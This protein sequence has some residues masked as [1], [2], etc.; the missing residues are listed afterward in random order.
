MARPADAAWVLVVPV[1][2]GDIAKSRLTGVTAR[3]RT[4]LARAFP[5]DCTEAAL[6]CRRVD[7]AVVVTDDP[8]AADAVRA[9]G[10]DVIADEPDAG[11]NPALQHA[12]AHVQRRYGPRPVAVISGDLPALR[13]AELDTALAR[14]SGFARA[15]VHDHAGTGTTLLTAAPGVDLDP[16]FGHG[17]RQRHARSGAHELDPRGLD[18]LR[19]DVDTWADLVDACRLGV[20]RHTTAVMRRHRLAA[21]RQQARD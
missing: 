11:L 1:K 8:V 4:D 3:Q 5:A 16:R 10:A 19:R 21:V 9:L 17:S 18:G 12:H 6:A 7:A 15:F 14:A 13:A 2:R 20:G